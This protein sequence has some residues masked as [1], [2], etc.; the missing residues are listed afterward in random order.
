[1]HDLQRVEENR[2]ADPRA[3]SRQSYGKHRAKLCNPQRRVP[4][5]VP[6]KRCKVFAT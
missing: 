3:G 6:G 4:A 5:K 1:M 2:L